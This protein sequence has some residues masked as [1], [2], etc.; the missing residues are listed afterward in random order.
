MEENRKI[1]TPYNPAFEDFIKENSGRGSLKVQ[2]S[3]ASE[4]FP[5]K[6]VTVEIVLDYKGDRYLL[7]KDVTDS[8]GIVDKIA[9]PARPHGDS[10]TPE[11]AESCEVEYL[12]SAFSP[13][14]EAVTDSPVIIH[15]RTETILPIALCPENGADC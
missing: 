5:V 2:V 3:T 7:Y 12:V 15:D 8:S 11:T 4:T 6:G 9:L 14:F 1:Q 10:Q 13:G